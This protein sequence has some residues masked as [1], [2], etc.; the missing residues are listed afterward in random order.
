MFT[1]LYANL[2]HI[3]IV[4]IHIDTIIYFLENYYS[5]LLVLIKDQYRPELYNL[6]S[7]QKKH[8]IDSSLSLFFNQSL[9]KT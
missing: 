1:A 3:Y 6:T 8:L 7:I 4:K 2:R 5:L 9:T